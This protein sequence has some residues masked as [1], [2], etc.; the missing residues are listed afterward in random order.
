MVC[1]RIPQPGSGVHSR[2]SGSLFTVRLSPLTQGPGF[3]GTERRGGAARG[4]LTLGLFLTRSHP[5]PV[6][7]GAC[8]YV[9]V[10]G[11]WLPFLG[12]PEP[13]GLSR[14]QR[15]WHLGWEGQCGEGHRGT[16]Q[17][18]NDGGILPGFHVEVVFC[19]LAEQGLPSDI[20]DALWCQEVMPG[21]AHSFH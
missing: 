18:T 15:S 13:K 19:Y 11:P 17:N 3:L 7:E 14:L 1:Q 6:T 21:T 4:E 2:V 8:V 9:C 10:W 5:L 12:C 20:L 16:T